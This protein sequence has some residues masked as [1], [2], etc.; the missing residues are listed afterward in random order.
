MERLSRTQPEAPYETLAYHFSRSHQKEKAAEYLVKAGEKAA[1]CYANR[2]ALDH[3]QN[4]LPLIP[5]G[6]ASDR[7]L[8]YCADLLLGLFQGK[9]AASAYERLLANARQSGNH[10]EE[11]ASLVGLAQAYYVVSL[12]DPNPEVGAR[13]LALGR[14][15]YSLAHQ[16]EDRRTIVRIPLAGYPFAR[17]RSEIPYDAAASC[18]EALA[19][20]Q[21]IGDDNLIIDASWTSIIIRSWVSG[22]T[23]EVEQQSE[24][25]RKRLEARRDLPRLKEV[26]FRL[27]QL[28]RHRGNFARCIE[29][30]DAGIRLAAE[31]GALPVMYPTEKAHAL[32]A[33]GR[34]GEAWASLQ[35]EIADETHQFARMSRDLCTGL[36]FLELMDYER[37]AG[38]LRLVLDEAT[39]LHRRR[40]ATDARL[41]L[42]TARFAPNS[43]S[44]PLAACWQRS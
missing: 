1:H 5:A 39:R 32:I 37:A 25:L 21:E 28:H 3:F 20:S 13:S 23:A 18:A 43:S 44:P 19:L 30:C 6:E 16:L 38:I 42:A 7:V 22:P 10:A 29:C 15:A 40:F 35:Q 31:I 41:L 36:Y 2:D 34:Y 4:A 24:D 12:D 9:E 11:L 33:L 14:Q 27:M 17:L 26:Y 8:G